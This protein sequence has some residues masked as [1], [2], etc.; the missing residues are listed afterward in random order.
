MLKKK[1]NTVKRNMIVLNNNF[2]I[3][4]FNFPFDHYIIDNFFLKEVADKICKDF[5][6]T[7]DDGWFSYKNPLENKKTIQNWGKFPKNTYKA[8]QYFCSES[9]ISIIKEITGIKTLYPDYGLHGGGWHMHGRGGNLNVHKDYSIHPK[10]GLQRKL[11]L[12]VYMSK[13]W[14]PEWGGGLEFWSHDKEKNKPLRLEKTIEC[15]YNRAVL[16]DTTQ[17]SW[18]GLPKPLVCPQNM[19]R[20]SVAIYYL[21]DVNSDTEE[22]YRAFFAPTKQQENDESVLNLI[23]KR[24]LME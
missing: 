1:Q 13:E 10:L 20:K 7:D 2:S 15:V 17:D 21:T 14:N 3:Q 9:F 19:F 23:K 8:F 11:N 6:D 12:I 18:H 4:K 16:F 5:P 22:R 24:Q